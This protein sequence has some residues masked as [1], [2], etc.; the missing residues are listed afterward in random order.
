MDTWFSAIDGLLGGIQKTEDPFITA[1]KKDVILYFLCSTFINIYQNMIG[2]DRPVY[3]EYD[4]PSAD[5]LEKK[6]VRGSDDDISIHS[7]QS[8]SPN[9]KAKLKKQ[10][11]QAVGV[12]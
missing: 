2:D 9:F 6:E 7:I 3:M 12:K 10:V 8:I 1:L 5:F 4:L 11:S